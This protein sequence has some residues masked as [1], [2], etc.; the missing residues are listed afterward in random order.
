MQNIIPTYHSIERVKERI[1]LDEEKAFNQIKK[2]I[3]RGKTSKDFTSLERKYLEGKFHDNVKALVYNHFCYIV[4]EEGVC[5]TIHKL[6][7]WF[8]KRRSY[9]GKDRIKKAK[10]YTRK[11]KEDD[12]YDSYEL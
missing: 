10:V 5:I 4:T 7:P 11:H 12:N 2:A 9:N 3:T 1:C 8:G 6:P